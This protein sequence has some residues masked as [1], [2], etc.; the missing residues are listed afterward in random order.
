MSDALLLADCGNSRIKW[1]LASGAGLEMGLPFS[2]E[3]TDLEAALDRAWRG[4]DPPAAVRV[5]NVAG[6]DVAA[7][8]EFSGA[9][10]CPCGLPGV[11]ARPA[12]F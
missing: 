10:G 9:G 7:V 1:A 4:L 6:P 5:S 2:Y 11:G 12:A 8:L 3:A